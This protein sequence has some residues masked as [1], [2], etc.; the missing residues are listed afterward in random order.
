MASGFFLILEDLSSIMDGAATMGKVAA[1]KTAA[2]LGD[3]L[4]INAE[5]ASGFG[6][7]REIPVLW[8]ITKGSFLNKIIILPIAFVLSA[9]WPWAINGILILGA[10]FLAFEGVEKIFEFIDYLKKRS[11]KQ[12][13][14]QIKEEKQEA[15]LSKEETKISEKQKIKSAILTDFVL[16]IEIVIIALGSVD[17]APIQQQIVIVTVVSFLAT[18]GVYGIVAFIVK[19][20]DIGYKLI[21]FNDRDKSFSDFI[22]KLLVKTLPL[23]IKSLAVI[24]TIA[25]LLV[26]GGIFVHRVEFMHD[27][28]HSLPIIIKEIITSLVAGFFVF[29]IVKMSKAIWGKIRGNKQPA[30][31]D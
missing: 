30:E 2:V 27:I 21:N 17:G 28:I 9:F 22:G 5:K 31:S 4:A 23:I 11:K 16:S 19:L 3:D 14:E 6:A 7:S 24:G 25:L 8:A 15:K 29:I 12:A 13:K 18:I 1:G 20:D 10:F 26:S